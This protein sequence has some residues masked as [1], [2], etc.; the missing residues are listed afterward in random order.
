MIIATIGNAKLKLETV[1]DAE[2]LLDIANLG[3]LIEKSYDLN[4]KDYF[5]VGQGEKRIGIEIIEGDTIHP[6][7]HHLEI[8]SA[9]AAAEKAKEEAKIAA[10]S[11]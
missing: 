3:M 10:V 5:Y 7:E 11:A 2:A 9:R 1:K 4:Y 6:F 8:I